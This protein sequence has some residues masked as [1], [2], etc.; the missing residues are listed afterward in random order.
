MHLEESSRT[1][2]GMAKESDPL[3]NATASRDA[4]GD[5]D[6]AP[7]PGLSDAIALDLHRKL[8]AFFRRRLSNAN[9]AEDLVQETMLRIVRAFHDLRSRDRLQPWIFRIAGGVLA[10]YWKARSR[11]TESGLDTDEIP[12]SDASTANAAKDLAG[13][14]ELFTR[15]LP[16]R[17]REAVELSELSELPHREIADR[18]GLSVSGVKSRVQ[19]GREQ[20]KLLVLECCA[21][22]L[23]GGEV[24]SVERRATR[25][26][27]ESCGCAGVATAASEG[28]CGETPLATDA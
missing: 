25:A 14:L 28:V 7:T 13:C 26:G 17:Y 5:A 2:N 11:T 9:D 6:F 10:D 19:R 27:E 21:V 3:D 16:E 12:A 15:R 18:L 22:D 23:Y 24:R 20:L 1:V 8:L 4:E